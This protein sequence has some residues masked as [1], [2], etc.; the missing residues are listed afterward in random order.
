MVSPFQ[1]AP[2]A[3]V[4][5]LDGTLID[6]RGDIAAAVNHALLADGRKA[7]TPS[8]IASFV[9]DGSRTLLARCAR[10]PETDETLDRLLESFTEYYLAHPIDFTKWAEGAP[11]V[12]DRVAELGLPIALCTN[13]ARDITEAVLS[14]LGVRTRFRAIF[15]GG[16]GPEKKPAPG[17]LLALSKKLG[18]DITGLVM[19]GDGPQD[20]ECARRAGCR[21]VGVVSTYSARDR[22]A[23]AQPDVVIETLTELPEILRRWGDATT[24]LQAIRPRS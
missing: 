2:G 7:L 8:V 11:D 19:V 1:V 15:A 10:L 13:K 5:D 3:V 12:L 20:I 21:V 4:F 17:P 24:R 6:S 22:V 23:L 9:G 14:S 16:D 18:Q